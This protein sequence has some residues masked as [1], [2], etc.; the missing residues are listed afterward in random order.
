MLF[1]F[2][3]SSFGVPPLGGPVFFSFHLVSW[4]LH[5]VDEETKKKKKAPGRLKAGLRTLTNARTRTKEFM[6]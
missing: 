2:S 4:C 1:F 3:L 6:P 5:P